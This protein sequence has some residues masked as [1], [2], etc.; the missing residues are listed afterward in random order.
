[1]GSV[2]MILMKYSSKHSGICFSQMILGPFSMRMFFSWVLDD[3]LENSGL[4]VFQKHLSLPMVAGSK[5]RKTLFLAT[6]LSLTIFFLCIYTYECLPYYDLTILFHLFRDMWFIISC[7]SCFSVLCVFIQLRVQH[8]Y[9]MLC[10]KCA[11]GR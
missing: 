1:M 7:N 9:R 5:C 2:V 3:F 8:G 10:S 6:L 11:D 4:R